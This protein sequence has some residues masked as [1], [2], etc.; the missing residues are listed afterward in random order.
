MSIVSG[1]INIP[2]V[3]MV[4][5]S[6]G[7]FIMAD[8]IGVTG[9]QISSQ[10]T[11]EIIGSINMSGDIGISGYNHMQGSI[12]VSGDMNINNGLTR[13]TLNLVIYGTMETTGSMTITGGE[14]SIPDG[15]IVMNGTG[16]FLTGETITVS[17]SQVNSVGT[18]EITGDVTMRGD[19]F[20]IGGQSYIK[21][22]VTVSGSLDINGGMMRG[23]GTIVVSD[24]SMQ[25]VGNMKITNGVILVLN[26]RIVMDSTGTHIG[27]ATSITGDLNVAGT[28]VNSGLVSMSGNF[29]I[30]TPLSITG[31]MVTVGV[32]SMGNLGAINGVLVI[33]GNVVMSG[34]TMISGDNNVIGSMT[35]TPLGVSING[36]VGLT[37][38]VHTTGGLPTMSSS[39]A[40][41]IYGGSMMGIPLPHTALMADPL[42]LLALGILGF[43]T[44]YVVFRSVYYGIKE[45]RTLVPRIRRTGETLRNA[46]NRVRWALKTFSSEIERMIR[47]S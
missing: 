11:T 44:I 34:A 15:R 43:G 12:T 26:G 29:Q 38:I 37:G 1:E 32:T 3:S 21:G 31:S 10:G 5:N 42:A 46:G 9:D 6:T 13:G 45:R 33:T 4:M 2:G 47:R 20:E 25:T 7:S 36:I 27:S 24:G 41:E 22:P 19:Y 35:I 18:I 39:T 8:A 40:L 23:T 30:L 28:I 17:G 14:I 16:S